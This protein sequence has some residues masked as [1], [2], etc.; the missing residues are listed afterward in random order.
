MDAATWQG[1]HDPQGMLDF[2]RSSGHLTE[3]G[4]R[5]FIAALCRQL[6]HRL[7]DDR[8][9]EAVAVAEDY[10]DGL[11]DA[12]A[13]E[14]AWGSAML[15]AGRPE[16]RGNETTWLAAEAVLVACHEEFRGCA[17]DDV[18]RRLLDALRSG[19]WQGR[20][21]AVGRKES[22][23]NAGTRCRGDPKRSRRPTATQV[24]AG[25]DGPSRPAPGSG[26]LRYRSCR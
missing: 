5:L 1:C 3:R 6:W 8:C 21:R 10:A 12:A 13:L 7:P 15:A 18:A 24:G 20:D 26:R 25:R 14:T 11:V 9:R 22:G 16:V 17:P 2:L 23:K 4:A 19:K